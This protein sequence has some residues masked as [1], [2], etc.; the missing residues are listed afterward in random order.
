MVLG[1]S[2]KELREQENTR[3]R[4]EKGERLENKQRQTIK[5]ADMSPY[6]YLHLYCNA[7]VNQ[8]HISNVE[9]G[10]GTKKLTKMKKL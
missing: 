5:E 8:K 3:K 4:Q 7:F 2:L 9:W 1:R 10:E 6:I